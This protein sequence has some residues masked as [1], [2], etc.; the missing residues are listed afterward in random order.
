MDSMTESQAPI[1][2]SYPGAVNEDD[3]LEQ[4]IQHLLVAVEHEI[5]STPAGMNEL[6]LIKALQ[7]QPWELLGDVVFSEPEKLY[8]VHFLLF[9][10]LYRLR[11]QLS[12]AGEN[13]Q[14]SPLNI[15]IEKQS[16]VSG[17]GVPDGVDTLRQFY[18]D[19]SQYRLPEEAIQRMMNDFWAGEPGQAP[20]Q[21][22]T[23][24]AAEILGFQAV[25]SDFPTV[26]KRFR[27]AVMNAHPDRGGKTETIQD[28]NQAFA[29]LK[30]HFRH[31]I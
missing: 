21:A 1:K 9:H 8:P 6:S 25:P 20:A 27:R 10:V 4:Q 13:L 18:L 5:R 24:E 7:G 23:R 2:M 28:L 12:E 17:E 26:K 3:C 22:E 31:N 16:V 19:L 30:A 14:I 15:R 29:V 11:D